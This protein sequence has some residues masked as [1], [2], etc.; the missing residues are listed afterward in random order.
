MIFG[1]VRYVSKKLPIKI[2]T[3]VSKKNNVNMI[4]TKITFYK[5]D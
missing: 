4:S 5:D 3:A 1:I 2:D